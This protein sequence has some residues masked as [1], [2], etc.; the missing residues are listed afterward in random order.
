MALLTDSDFNLLT[1]HWAVS[2][3]KPNDLKRSTRLINERTA[4]SALEGQIK[5]DFAYKKS[6]DRLLERVALAY[7]IAATEGLDALVNPSDKNEV[8]KL[9]RQA[10]ASSSRAF[11]VLRLSPVPTAEID[12]LFTVLRI[13]ALAYC[14]DRWSDLK[15]WYKKTEHTLHIPTVEDA[16]WDLRLL[17]RLFDCW[18]RLFQKNGWDDLYEIHKIIAELR[19][20]QKYFEKQQLENESQTPSPAIAFRLVALYHWA[21][22]TEILAGYILQGDLPDPLSHIDKHFE[23]G[24]KAAAAAGDASQEM[25]LRWLHATGHAMITNSLW[26]ATR[27]TNPRTTKFVAALIKHDNRPMFELLPPQRAALLEQGLLDQATTAIVIDIPTSGGKTLLAQFRILQALNQFRADGGW[28]AYVAPTRALSAQITRKLKKDFGPIGLRVERL[29]TAVEVDAFEDKFLSEASSSN[30]IDPFDILVATPEK[31]SLVIR[32]KKVPR[33]LVLLVMDE[34]HNIEDP[35]RGLRIEFLLAT[36]KRDCHKANFLL[37]MPY[38]EEPEVIARWLAD[39]INAGKAI[40]LSTTPWKP[41]ERIIGLYHAVANDKKTAGWHLVYETLTVTPKAMPLRGVHRVGGVKPINVLKSKVLNVKRRKQK[42]FGLQTAA[43]SS[44]MSQRGTSI[45]VGH[46]I[47]TVWSMAKMAA[48]NLP[49]HN[50]VPEDI[51]LVQDFLRTEISSDFLLI[52]MLAR[53]VGVHHA[54][55]S[56]DIRSLMEWLA[57]TGALRMLCSTST[58]AQGM[59]FPVSSLFLASRFIF[60]QDKKNASITPR[61]FW[62]LAG[63]VGRTEHDSIGVVGLPRGNNRTAMINFV[64]RSTGALTSRII[65]LLD[66]LASQR[67]LANLDEV[68]CE[69]QW[70]DFR[71]YIAHLWSEKKNLEA[72]LDDS[73]E[74]L[75]HTYGY[76]E[77]CNDPK[78]KDKADALLNAARYY[79]H[80]LEE[81]QDEIP[82]LA[83]STGFTPEGV[84]QAIKE[85]E[86]LEEKLKPL[87]WSPER[88]FGDDGKLADLFG[89]ML[90]IPQL[91]RQLE[92]IGN[93]N[94]TKTDI[95]NITRD[96]VNGKGLNQIAIEYFQRKRD[97][98]GTIALT[99]A[100]KA[101]YRAI[102]N[103]G[104]WGISAL[105]QFS[106]LQFDALSATE[107]RQIRT[108]PAMIYHGVRTEEA[109]LM[110]MNSVPRSA[111]EAAGELY[112][113]SADA[114]EGWHSIGKAR[115]FLRHLDESGWNKVRSEGAALSGA[116]YQ[117]VWTILSG[118]TE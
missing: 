86:N 110:R 82:E 103:S 117:R 44:I 54:G 84:S 49:K 81:M 60:Q 114:K 21:K 19:N 37:L 113:K 29:T 20:D 34:A 115:V 15:R 32:N 2:A 9:R 59:N 89:I 50:P 94:F 92:D 10:I 46:N 112:R 80:K 27:S 5:F 74:L 85:L 45:A 8:D 47:P 42:G 87:D 68:L 40:S 106:N 76:T 43:I 23:A 78:Q 24:A 41:N 79:A 7:E 51:C 6:D 104:T 11:D 65:S 56:D 28:V 22:A 66:S 90:E 97:P 16:S 70:E 12:R 105:S 36:V 48:Q 1:S 3:I 72:V 63:R 93:E 109:V 111:A 102:V 88:L 98:D 116:G 101:I 75:R 67:E 38:V 52:E 4:Q 18:I 91:K 33:P 57:E 95:A 96:W 73:E 64:S 100:C 13:S 58:I 107:R 61:E 71:C 69:D 26:W 77:L 14:G 62:N 31:L 35:G 99:D 30:G 25:S 108:L 39:D 53:G 55:L 83:D 17:Y 118:D